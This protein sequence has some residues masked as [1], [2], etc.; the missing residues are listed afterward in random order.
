MRQGDHVMIMEGPLRGVRAYVMLAWDDDVTGS[1]ARVWAHGFEP[2]VIPQCHLQVLPPV[3]SRGAA[4]VLEEIDRLLDEGADLSA[5]L[6]RV[7]E[8]DGDAD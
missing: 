6:R 4:A 8:L 5:I 1:E 3:K 7:E 2:A